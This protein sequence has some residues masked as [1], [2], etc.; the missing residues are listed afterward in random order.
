MLTDPDKPPAGSRMQEKQNRMETEDPTQEIPD[1]LQD[2]T[3]NLED[4]EKHVPA[5]FS[6]GENPDSAEDVM[7]DLFRAQKRL[8]T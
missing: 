2:F 8:V 1:W 4:L 7:N 3:A 6:E 5:H